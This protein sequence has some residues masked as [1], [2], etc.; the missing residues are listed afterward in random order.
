MEQLPTSGTL[1]TF[2]LGEEWITDSA[3]SATAMSTGHKTFNGRVATSPEGAPLETLF[4]TLRA[5]GYAVGVVATGDLNGATAAS[6]ITNA[7]SRGDKEP[8][9]RGIMRFAPDVMVGNSADFFHENSVPPLSPQ[10]LRAA[11][12]DV[13]IDEPFE[14]IVPGQG[15]L[16]IGYSEYIDEARSREAGRNVLQPGAP[17]LAQAFRFAAEYLSRASDRGFFLLVEEDWIDSW[18]HENNF[19]L[20]AEMVVHLDDTVA[21]AHEYSRADQRTLLVVTSDH[22]C[23]GLTITSAG[24]GNIEAQFASEDHTAQ[25]VPLFAYGP[26]AELFEGRVDNT[27]LRE[28]ILEMLP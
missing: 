27:E 20:L 15:P 8:I 6:F 26:G 2:S 22:E 21:A 25:A 7:K 14:E 1:E 10:A 5:R 11:G 3:A 16:L 24:P 19:P 17:H 23:C 13:H 18:G 12:W 4:E 28:R 9:S